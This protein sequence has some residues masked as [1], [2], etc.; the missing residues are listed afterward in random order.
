MHR[1]IPQLLE[2]LANGKPVHVPPLL[3]DAV[4]ASQYADDRH[5]RADLHELA[6]DIRNGAV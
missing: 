3:S 2:D 5:L 6:T 1:L 4:P